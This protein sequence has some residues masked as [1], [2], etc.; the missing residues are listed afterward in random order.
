[1]QGGFLYKIWLQKWFL[2]KQIGLN[3]S[4]DPEIDIYFDIWMSRAQIQYIFRILG[5]SRKIWERFF[6]K[7]HSHMRVG[8]KPLCPKAWQMDPLVMT[9]SW[10]SSDNHAN[11]RPNPTFSW[12]TYFSYRA[13]WGLIFWEFLKWDNN[14]I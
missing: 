3:R 6:W 2:I 10:T 1:M 9:F 13:T 12:R 7:S 8:A 11:Y 5:I 4:R 14:I